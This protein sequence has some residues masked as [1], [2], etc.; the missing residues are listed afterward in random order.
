[1]DNS[2]CVGDYELWTKAHPYQTIPAPFPG[3]LVCPCQTQTPWHH[4]KSCLLPIWDSIPAFP[5]IHT[6]SWHKYPLE[7]NPFPLPYYPASSTCYIISVSFYSWWK[8]QCWLKV[9]IFL[10]FQVS[11]GST[12][13]CKH[14]SGRCHSF[15]LYLAIFLVMSPFNELVEYGIYL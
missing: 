15:L 6:V 8:P 4:P 14:V 12:A 3:M 10:F 1:M 7:F 11:L 13:I 2:S 5:S 9:P